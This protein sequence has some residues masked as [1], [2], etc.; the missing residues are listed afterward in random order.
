MG[1]RPCVT[2]KL[3]ILRPWF[4]NLILLNLAAASCYF[5]ASLGGRVRCRH[6]F[7]GRCKMWNCQC[8]TPAGCICSNSGA[9]CSAG[10]WNR[11]T[12]FRYGDILKLVP[13]MLASPV[14]LLSQQCWFV[15]EEAEHIQGFLLL[16]A[17]S[18]LPS[19]GPKGARQ[20]PTE[21]TK[22]KRE[23]KAPQPKA[24]TESEEEAGRERCGQ[25]TWSSRD[26]S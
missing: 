7:I 3:P 19:W 18:T 8:P 10:Q 5:I 4:W 2:A 24:R 11:G 23:R 13:K 16:R 15:R 25:G 22:E 14:P 1:V 26:Y 12:K 21:F 9:I 20:K 17:S 6:P